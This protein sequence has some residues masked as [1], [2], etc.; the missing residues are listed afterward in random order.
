M[1]LGLYES[2]ITAE[3]GRRLA[4]LVGHEAD[5]AS[6][7]PADQTHV[8]ARHLGAALQRRLAAERDPV[9]RLALANQVLAL[10][11]ESEPQRR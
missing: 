7:D 3:L 10:I 2:V 6:V 11:D 5:V 4:A 1:E 8:L 9:T